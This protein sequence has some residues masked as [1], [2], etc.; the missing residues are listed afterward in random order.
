[1]LEVARLDETFQARSS[2]SGAERAAYERRRAELI[3]RLRA[4]S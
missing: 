3:R 2:P 1:M 4:S